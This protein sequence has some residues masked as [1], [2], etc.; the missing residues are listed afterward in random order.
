MHLLCGEVDVSALAE[1]EMMVV[2]T[3]GRSLAERVAAL[4]AELAQVREDLVAFRKQFD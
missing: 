1:G 2:G 4:E 3:P